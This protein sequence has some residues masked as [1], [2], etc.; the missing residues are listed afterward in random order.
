[1]DRRILSFLLI[2]TV[3]ATALRFAFLVYNPPALNWDEVSHGYNAYSVLKTGMDQWGQKFPIF[4]FRAYGDYPTTLN[5][6]L[7]VPFILIF[8]FTEFAIRFPHAL[9]GV[10]TVVSV[11]FFTWGVTKKKYLSLFTAGLLAIGPWYIFTSRFVLQSNLSVFLLTIA[12][13]L[14]FN[15]SKSKFFL[16]LTFIALFLTLFSYHTTRIF[17]PLLL[18]GA[19]IIYMP[20]NIK[21]LGAAL[22]F[23]VLTGFILQ[24]PENRA[25]GGVLFLIDQGAINRIIEQRNSSKLPEIIKKAVYNRPVYFVEQFSKNYVS[26][27]SPKFLF[28]SGGT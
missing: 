7:T 16:L 1:M 22:L 17:S 3:I 12:G 15:R 20:K 26:Y 11:Y 23:F 21:I 13:A 24:N 14:F 5:L 28:F 25:R 27:F 2:I 6:Y 9:L 18:I 19:L 10:L 8:G 4:N